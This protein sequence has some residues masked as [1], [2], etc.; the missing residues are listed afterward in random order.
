MN[1]EK[2]DLKNYSFKPFSALADDWA[3]LTAGSLKKHNAM[4]ISW[5]GFG[6]LWHKLSATVFV[7]PQ[8][9]TKTLIDQNERFTLNFFDEE[10]KPALQFCGTNS[11]F[12]VKN[13]DEATKLVAKEFDGSVGYEQSRM[14]LVCKK[15]FVSQMERANFLNSDLVKQFYSAGDFHYIYIAEIE[16]A[17]RKKRKVDSIS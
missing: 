16:A 4:T 8:R 10:F 14:V 7:R 5:G 13:K 2:I 3:L 6:I 9:F 17:Y 15:Q 12:D 11:G 1:F